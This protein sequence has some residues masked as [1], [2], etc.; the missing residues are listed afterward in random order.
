MPILEAL[1]ES[2]PNFPNEVLQDWLRPYAISEGWPPSDTLET[3]PEGRWRFSGNPPR[4]IEDVCSLTANLPSESP[5]YVVTASVWWVQRGEEYGVETLVMDDES[6]EDM[7]QYVC[8]RVEDRWI[9]IHAR[10]TARPRMHEVDSD[11]CRAPTHGP[12]RQLD[13][14]SSSCF[15]HLPT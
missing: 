1:K 5:I 7:E 14:I 12:F 13:S 15:V 3:L 10:R 2:L 4:L 9:E 8:Q 11:F 6:R